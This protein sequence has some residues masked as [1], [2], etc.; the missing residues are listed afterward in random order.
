VVLN[1]VT[2]TTTLESGSRHQYDVRR[3]RGNGVSFWVAFAGE[4]DR[5]TFIT[6][7]RNV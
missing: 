6:I 1:S 4:G 7:A 5:A 3:Y 2:S